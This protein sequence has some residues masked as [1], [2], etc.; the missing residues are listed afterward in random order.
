MWRYFGNVSI[1]ASGFCL[2]Y[3]LNM[4]VEGRMRKIVVAVTGASGMPLALKLMQMLAQQRDIELG[5][6]VSSA[7]RKVLQKENDE[8]EGIFWALAKDAWHPDDFGAGPASGTWWQPHE[9][10][11]MVI[12]P[13]SMNTLGAL[14]AGIAGN[15]VHRAADVALKEGC[16]LVLVARE[17]PLSLIHLHNMLVMRKAGAI[18]MPFSPTFYFQPRTVDDILVQFCWRIFDQLGISHSGP[19]WGAK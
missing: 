7:A 16:R 3:H 15:L 8:D 11:G 14:A 1:L 10:C 4:I 9:D 13:C 12:V 2:L 5:C 18:I 19:K 17:S 6:I